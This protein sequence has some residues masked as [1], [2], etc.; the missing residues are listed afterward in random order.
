MKP[1]Q[2]MQTENIPTDGPI[3]MGVGWRELLNYKHI[4]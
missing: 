4:I 2:G 1:F 3:N